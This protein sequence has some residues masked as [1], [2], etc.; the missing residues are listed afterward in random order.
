MLSLGHRVL[1]LVTTVF[2]FIPESALE[3]I[4][5]DGVLG[6]S[7]CSSIFP[8]IVYPS[9][10]YSLLAQPSNSH[11]SQEPRRNKPGRLLFYFPVAAAYTKELKHVIRSSSFPAVK[12]WAKEK[13]REQHQRLVVSELMLHIPTWLIRRFH[14]ACG[15]V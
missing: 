13:R 15:I 12:Q 3:Q 11:I 7:R 9:M 1:T 10:L 6:T 4:I 5:P 14:E 2:S 8:Y